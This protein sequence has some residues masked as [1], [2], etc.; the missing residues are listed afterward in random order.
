FRASLHLVENIAAGLNELGGN[1]KSG[2]G[3]D[4]ISGVALV[5]QRLK[6]LHALLADFSPSQAANQFFALAG[7]HW[8]HHDLNPAHV[9]FDDVHSLPPAARLTHRETKVQAPA[10][11]SAFAKISRLKNGA[12]ALI[13]ATRNAS[14]RV[15]RLRD[16]TPQA[17]W[18]SR[19]PWPPANTSI[20]S[21]SSTPSS[22][23]VL[24]STSGSRTA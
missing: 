7:K 6:D 24:A 3:H 17:P 16:S 4:S 15:M 11:R 23:T 19:I 2:V 8:P 10:L 21:E 14:R 12:N 13:T 18:A 20:A 5:D 9:A 1:F 22:S